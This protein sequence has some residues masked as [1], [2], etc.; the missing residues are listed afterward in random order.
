MVVLDGLF[1]GHVKGDAG[2]GADVTAD[3]AV[4]ASVRRR[5]EA[6]VRAARAGDLDV[7]IGYDLRFWRELGD[8]IGNSYISDFLDRLRVQCWVYSVP[9]L[10]GERDV[11]RRL[12]AGHRELV[13]AVE[14]QDAVESRRI[15]SE[16]HRQSLELAGGP[17]MPLSP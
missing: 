11:A 8:L 17:A 16:Y 7:L 12:W 9:C 3:P 13:D 14:R 2:R 6:A 4:L 1:H 15:V 10:R 5:A